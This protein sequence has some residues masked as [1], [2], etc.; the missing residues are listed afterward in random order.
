MST[1]IFTML[2]VAVM[3]DTFAPSRAFCVDHQVW[4]D[5]QLGGTGFTVSNGDR[6]Q[7]LVDPGSS[8]CCEILDASVNVLFNS[9]TVTLFS[10]LPG[11]VTVTG[12]ARGNEPPRLGTG[13]SRVC[14]IVPSDIYA[15]LAWI[16]IFAYAPTANVRM[17]CEET[18]LYG[19]FNTSVTDFNFLEMTNTSAEGAAPISGSVT[20]INVVAT[21]NVTVIDRIGFSV[22][23][24]SRFDFDIHART[25]FGAFGPVKVAHDGAPGSLKAVMSQYVIVTASPL[26]FV[27]MAQEVL[28]TRSDSAGPV[29]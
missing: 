1:R 24:N 20:A 25:G 18:T 27:P 22:N 29:K 13:N 14:F 6:L 17:F 10:T 19:G 28:R 15:P 7:T 21:P 3:L 4:V 2:L 26:D 8:Y 23:G 12:I 5:R 11:T 16:D 9:V